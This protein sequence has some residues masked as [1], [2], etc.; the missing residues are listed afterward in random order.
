MIA[1][2]TKTGR[3]NIIGYNI[4]IIRK[5]LGISQRELAERLWHLGLDIDKNAI[6][7]MESGQRLITDI[8]VVYLA[9]CLNLS[10]M[11][12]YKNDFD[13]PNPE[14]IMLENREEKNMRNG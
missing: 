10:I 7:R 13:A 14:E 12:L 2:R 3:T 1:N 4:A 11:S 8:E 6:Q 9:K 5:K